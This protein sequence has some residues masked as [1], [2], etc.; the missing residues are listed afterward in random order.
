LRVVNRDNVSDTCRLADE[1]FWAGG[2][3]A[4]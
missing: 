3:S 2:A 4:N 1:V